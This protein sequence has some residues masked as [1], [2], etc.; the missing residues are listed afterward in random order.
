MTVL[1]KPSAILFDWDD[2]IVDTW[3]VVRAAVNSTLVAMGKAAWTEE[4]ARANLGPPARVL[5]TRLFGEDRWRE[6]DEIYISAYTENI[7]ANLRV[8]EQAEEVL[9]LL[10]ASRTY[11]AVVSAKRGPV[12]RQEAAHLGFDRYFKALVGAGDAEKDKPDPASVL[13]A[14]RGSGITPG[15]AVWL[16]GDSHTDMLCAHSAGCTPVLLETKPPAAE[17]LLAHPPALRLKSHLDLLNLLQ[18]KPGKYLNIR[19]NTP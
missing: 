17:S 13:L 11:M 1:S 15:P 19:S 8:H 10:S 9:K 12:L 16:V 14:L 7:A 3:P 2:T 18:E 5:F 6:A 4:E